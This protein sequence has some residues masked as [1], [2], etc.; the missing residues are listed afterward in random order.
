MN[1][2]AYLRASTEGQDATRAKEA[3]DKFAE[4]RSIS[5]NEY[6][7][8]NASGTKLKRPELMRLIETADKGDIL[9]VEQVDRLTRLTSEDWGLLKRTIEDKGI[10]IVS[11]DLPTSFEALGAN[12]KSFTGDILRAVNRMLMDILATTARK[13][14][15]DRKRRQLEGI[16]KAKA[17]KKYKGRQQTEDG[18]KAVQI[19]FEQI[20]LGNSVANSAKVAEISRAYGYKLMKLHN[21]A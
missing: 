4:D 8:E 14:Q 19:F 11:L 9:L 13:D 5:I 3:L 20:K 12:D 18:A 10:L 15:E 16:A 1:I 2:F 21:T 6:F 17:D 7:I